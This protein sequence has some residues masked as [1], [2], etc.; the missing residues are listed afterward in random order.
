MRVNV[1]SPIT[2]PVIEKGVFL[3]ASFVRCALG[4]V[5]LAWPSAEIE[6]VEAM[7]RAVCEE[8]MG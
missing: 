3:D 2:R 6:A 7:G 1:K 5:A 4:Q 8:R